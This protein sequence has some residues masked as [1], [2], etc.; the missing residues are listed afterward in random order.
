MLDSFVLNRS[1]N[2]TSSLMNK[3]SVPQSCEPICLKDHFA[4]STTTSKGDK[5]DQPFGRDV[6]FHIW[7]YSYH[8]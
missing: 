5:S 3:K 1:E 6:R 4:S 8:W 7:I 2:L